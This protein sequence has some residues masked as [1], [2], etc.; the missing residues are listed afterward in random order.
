[1]AASLTRWIVA[2]AIASLAMGLVLANA[3][4]AQEPAGQWH[5]T[6]TSPETGDGLR[7]GVEVVRGPEGQLT[8]FA[9]SPDQT[10][11]KIPIEAIKVEN[12]A[13][14]FTSQAIVGRYEGSWDPARNA[15]A[16]VWRQNGVALP[17]VL[18]KGPVPAAKP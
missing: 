4:M 8:G 10:D 2:L 3:A 14:S 1:M 18:A 5:G 9:T 7:I 12:G 11:Q 13:L 15:W 16:G 6:L 17:L